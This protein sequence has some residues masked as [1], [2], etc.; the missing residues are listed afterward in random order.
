M[1][2]IPSKILIVKN[3]KRAWR[4]W[5]FANGNSEGPMNTARKNAGNIKNSVGKYIP[6][7]EFLVDNVPMY[8]SKVIK[9]YCDSSCVVELE[10]KYE[11][12]IHV[13]HMTDVI[14]FGHIENGIIKSPLVW[15]VNGSQL[16]LV[17]YEGTLYN[18]I[19]KEMRDKNGKLST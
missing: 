4:P 14:M 11:V 18:Q 15:V 2:V 5:F 17:H 19:L 6:D 1:S 9:F 10:G 8:D 13:H 12:E 3:I 16:V 7:I